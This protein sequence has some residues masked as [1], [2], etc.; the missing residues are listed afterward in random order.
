LCPICGQQ[1]LVKASYGEVDKLRREASVRTIKQ[2]EL[3]RLANGLEEEE[4]KLISR[5]VAIKDKLN[6]LVAKL[7]RVQFADVSG[8]VGSNPDEL[9]ERLRT[10]KAHY[11]RLEVKKANLQEELQQNYT[12]FS[13]LCARR[14]AQLSALAA[15]YGKK[16]LGNKCEFVLTPS[17]E[18][19]SPFSFFVPLFSDKKREVP[20][21]CSESERFFLDIAFRM[22]VLTFAGLLS[23]T[24]STFICETPENALDL[25]YTD[26]VAAMFHKFSV[27]GFSILLTA[28]LQFGGV[29]KPLLH[30]YP[31]SERKR[32]S[33]N[34]IE[35]CDLSNVQTRKK[36]EFMRVYQ[37]IVG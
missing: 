3:Q 8:V 26:N 7:P 1:H 23:K 10:T 32:R 9:R 4:S 15:E 16:F 13:K 29:A 35:K 22:A 18:R 30:A 21:S 2:D 5:E 20:E 12:E 31:K 27:D 11:A 25:A 33:I 28:N 19:L 14:L 36:S 17:R 34:L 37:Q 24:R 6:L